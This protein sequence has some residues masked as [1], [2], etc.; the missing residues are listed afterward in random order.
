MSIHRHHP[1]WEE[2]EFEDWDD[3]P[4]RG[5]DD[6]RC[7]PLAALAVAALGIYAFCSPRRYC[8][9]RYCYPRSCRPRYDCYP[10]GCYPFLSCTPT[11]ICYPRTCYPV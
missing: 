9:P 5:E 8:R 2:P 10:L 6:E 7:A 11:Y 1:Y 3:T 4:E